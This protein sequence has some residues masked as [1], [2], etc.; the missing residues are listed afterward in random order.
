MDD[1]LWERV[2]V[3][4]TGP[5]LTAVLALFVLNQVTG[6]AQR[7]REANETRDVLTKG[8]TETGNSLYL[9]LQAFWRKA[10]DVPI[11]DRATSPDLSE[12]REKLDEL[13][14]R[15]RLGGQVIEQQLRI[16]YSS[17]EPAKNWHRVTDLLSVR[18]FLLTESNKVRRANICAR[19]AGPAHSGLTE[20]QLMNPQV[21]LNAY[22]VA[23]AG[24]VRSLWEYEID[25]N[26]K[27]M[28]IAKVPGGDNEGQTG[29]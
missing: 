5:V 15:A 28:Q 16:Y 25:R 22:R 9:G 8:V 2:L 19:N 18:Y 24:T 21:L 10:R 17:P 11:S 26:G 12:A 4:A 14:G 6:W 3:A 1:P 7:R 13:Y 27:H 23:L 29:D 20:A